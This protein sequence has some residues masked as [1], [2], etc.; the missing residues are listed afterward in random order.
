MRVVRGEWGE[1]PG[2][3]WLG[4]ED[5]GAVVY[6]EEVASKNRVATSDTGSYWRQRM[7]SNVDPKGTP[8][9]RSVAQLQARAAQF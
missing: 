1:G 3:C 5:I 8:D 2:S 4:E 7:A 9:A 6:L